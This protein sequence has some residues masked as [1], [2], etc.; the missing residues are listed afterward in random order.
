[1]SGKCVPQATKGEVRD[2]C[3]VREPTDFAGK[4][5]RKR[6]KSLSSLSLD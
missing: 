3:K 1:M 5:E 2:D 6:M 4:Y